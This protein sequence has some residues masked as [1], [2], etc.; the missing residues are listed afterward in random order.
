MKINRHGNSLTI[1]SENGF[2]A[3]QL[4]FFK[5]W[6]NLLFLDQCIS[7]QKSIWLITGAS[8]KQWGIFILE[9]TFYIHYKYLNF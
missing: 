7:S 3:N 6:K 1:S 4:F 8:E 9:L 2:L 5:V